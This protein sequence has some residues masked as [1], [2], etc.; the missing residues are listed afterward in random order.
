M[1]EEGT[2]VPTSLTPKIKDIQRYA[3]T[4]GSSDANRAGNAFF[5]G[6]IQ[7]LHLDGT[8]L[9]PHLI[10]SGCLVGG[11]KEHA[12]CATTSYAW[13]GRWFGIGSCRKPQEE[14][15]VQS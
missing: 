1:Q 9:D 8:R 12:V 4:K 14:A 15:V 6:C 2:S 10:A 5:S 3:G 13:H 11:M 7:Q